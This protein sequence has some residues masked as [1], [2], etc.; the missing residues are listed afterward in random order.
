MNNPV[1]RRGVL[2]VFAGLLAAAWG[3]VAAGVAGLFVSS[4]LRKAS[5]SGEI[6]AGRVSGFGPQFSPVR[7]RIPIKDGWYESEKL[8]LIYVRIPEG[9][10]PEA[11][12]G[13][14]THL[15]CTV[16]WTE[17]AGEFICPCHDA[18]FGPDGA[19]LGGPP[20]RPLPKIPVEVRGED[21][22]VRLA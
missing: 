11:F 4:P 2:G 14:C 1:T 15:S 5:A 6:L 8:K 12:S 17:S 9:G 21:V 3:A 10:V 22:F 7:L 16:K 18:R 20:P 19:V 13:T